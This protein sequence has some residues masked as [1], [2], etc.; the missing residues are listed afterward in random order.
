[1]KIFCYINE[2][3]TSCTFKSATR[4]GGALN[5]LVLGF[6]TS[7]CTDTSRPKIQNQFVL[8]VFNIANLSGCGHAY[9]LVD[10]Q[11][12]QKIVSFW[13]PSDEAFCVFE[14]FGVFVKIDSGNT[15]KNVF[16]YAYNETQLTID[17]RER[18]LKIKLYEGWNKIEIT[19]L[20]DGVMLEFPKGVSLGEILV[21]THDQPFVKEKPSK[22]FS[23]NTK[24]EEFIGTNSFVDVPLGLI[25]PF[26]IV[27][28]YHDWPDWNEPQKDSLFLD[29]SK[30]GFD[31]KAFYL[32]MTRLGKVCVPV[33]QKS[34]MWLTGNHKQ[35]AKPIEKG[36]DE[37]DPTSYFRAAK[38][39]QRYVENFT[40]PT[41]GGL[42]WFENGNE[43]DKWWEGSDCYQSPVG[44]AA[45]SS[46]AIDGHKQTINGLNDVSS[47][48]NLVMA[49]MANPKIENLNALKYW[50]DKNRSSSWPWKVLNFHE[51]SNAS[52]H[53]TDKPTKAVH[54]EKGRIF[55]TASEWVRF[56][57]IN[58]LKS[59]V[60]VSEFGFD[61]EESP[62]KAIETKKKSSEIVQAD[63]ILRSYFIYAMAGVDRAIQYMVRDFGKTGMYATSGLYSTTLKSEPYLK[64]SWN[65]LNQTVGI[66]SGCTLQKFEVDSTNQLYHLVY[67]SKEKSLIVHVFW[68]G[69]HADSETEIDLDKYGVTNNLK[70]CQLSSFEKL[71]VI[72]Q[73]GSKK[74]IIGETP[75][76]VQECEGD[77]FNQSTY[78]EVLE[79]SKVSVR[80]EKQTEISSLN[81]E[82]DL[83]NP[84]MGLSVKNAATFWEPGYVEK[85]N[86][87]V[88]MNLSEP[89]LVHSLSV[90]DG[91][92]EGVVDVYASVDEK[93]FEK[94]GEINMRLYNKWQ[95]LAINKK[96]K[97]I[98]L[99]F[100]KGKPE[101]GELKVNVKKS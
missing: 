68:L 39:F 13:K 16:I 37:T 66:L 23:S 70:L 7:S 47:K 29:L 71:P 74:I 73:P 81:D 3:L 60:W 30:T 79:N 43:P 61:T 41:K 89:H 1:M 32:N 86:E 19:K 49:G 85:A 27:R 28:E 40:D 9:R 55:Q 14:N 51:Y 45:F 58:Q 5:I 90:F 57:E 72:K 31:F 52:A 56:K 100:A 94:I 21:E 91:K 88:Y 44:Y 93:T 99:H 87:F 62:Q 34:P 46:A 10:E 18:L 63:W 48:F 76:F 75:V 36:K 101:I 17:E 50:S 11:N 80:N 20:T 26:G 15:I 96:V 97:V 42:V 12:A 84:V 53:H 95:S 98:K 22:T 54:P 83:G 4:F 35:L 8:T 78:L 82:S 64:P 24:F 38:F 2:L 59:E 69:T 77:N 67:A 33:I 6:L 92:G 25:E 65:Y